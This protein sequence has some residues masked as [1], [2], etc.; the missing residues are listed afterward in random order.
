MGGG[1]VQLDPQRPHFWG[2][3]ERSS[4]T[5]IKPF[6]IFH[7]SEGVYIMRVCED[8]M[9]GKQNAGK[10]SKFRTVQISPI[11]HNFGGLRQNTSWSICLIH[12]TYL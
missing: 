6:Q 9:L 10:N 4:K 8:N 1:G 11:L 2:K 3:G 12:M 7:N 5:D